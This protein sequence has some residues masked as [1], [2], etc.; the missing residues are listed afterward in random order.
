[1]NPIENRWYAVLSSRELR[2]K[3]VAAQR[4]SRNLVF[5]RDAE[6]HAVGAIDECPHRRAKLSIGRVVVGEIECPFHGFRFDGAGSCTK[7]PA[8]PERVIPSAMSLDSL[9]L[10]EEHDLIWI[11]T[12]PE[13]APSEPVPFFDFEGTWEGSE[14]QVPV[15]VHYT[16]AIEN[17]LDFAHL[18]F[19]HH[20]TIGRSL[21]PEM[22]IVTETDGDRVL[23]YRRDQRHRGFL[24]FLGPNVWR[25][26]TGPVWQF[27]AFVPI[28]AEHMLY[29]VRSYQKLV[30]LPGLRWLVGALSRMSSRPIVAQDTAV[31]ESQ[32][33]GE[34]FLRNRE[35]LVPSD[36]PIIAYRRW[37]EEHRSVR[38]FL[39]DADVPITALARGK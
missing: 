28:D 19:V 18:P 31:V 5:W 36:G 11:W 34:T 20:N 15:K 39:A 32:P 22:D 33:R 24:E 30:R 6:G 16:R 14:F 3:P 10:R 8:H 12:G 9:E 23:A 21:A 38:S 4:F 2:S 17:Q 25:L 37:R 27:L 13:S 26:K 7:I 29:Y 35:V 1:M